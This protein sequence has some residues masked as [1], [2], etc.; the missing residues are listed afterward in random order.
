MESLNQS[1]WRINTSR[2]HIGS[3][4]TKNG[5]HWESNYQWQHCSYISQHPNIYTCQKQQQRRSQLYYSYP[6]VL[7]RTYLG[8]I[9]LFSVCQY[10]SMLRHH[11]DYPIGYFTRASITIR[12]NSHIPQRMNNYYYLKYRIYQLSYNCVHKYT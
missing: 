8:W 11:I 12:M 7:E 1:L 6:K 3:I 9:D 2:Y 4:I 10:C 5:A